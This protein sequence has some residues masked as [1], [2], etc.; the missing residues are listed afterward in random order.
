MNQ[1]IGKSL[2]VIGWLAG[3]VFIA[4]CVVGILPTRYASPAWAMFF[5]VPIFCALEIVWLRL[6]W[7]RLNSWFNKP[8]AVS[9]VVLLV[10]LFASILY[11]GWIGAQS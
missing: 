5:G 4:I 3:F 9:V 1:A 11:V 8:V 6:A 7:R 2:A 10:L